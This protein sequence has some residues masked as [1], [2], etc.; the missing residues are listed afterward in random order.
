MEQYEGKKEGGV[1][2]V[3]VRAKEVKLWMMR[4]PSMQEQRRET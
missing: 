4:G 1:Q 3:R 2:G